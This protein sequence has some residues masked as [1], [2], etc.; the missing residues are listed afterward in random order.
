MRSQPKRRMSSNPERRALA[1][2]EGRIQAETLGTRDKGRDRESFHFCH[3]VWVQYSRIK[4]I[5][6]N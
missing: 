6:E 3:R 4:L 1:R 5:I 2:R